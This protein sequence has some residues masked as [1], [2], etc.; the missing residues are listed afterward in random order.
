MSLSELLRGVTLLVFC[1]MTAG[2]GFQLR[3]PP[4]IPETAG[5]IYIETADRYT[6]FYRRLVIELRRSG[7]ELADNPVDARTTIR[8]LADDHGRRLLSV[9]AR[10][11]PAEYE[12][13]YR[14]TIALLVA[15]QQV[16]PPEPLVLAREYTFDEKQ[17]LGKAAEEQALRRAI[18]DDLVSL[19]IR[20]LSAIS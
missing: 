4:D 13:Y 1:A 3:G 16:V 11:I 12:I 18:V 17:V 15:G 19:V 2:C 14:V 5:V 6:E 10:N 20:R 9:T 7:V 8:V